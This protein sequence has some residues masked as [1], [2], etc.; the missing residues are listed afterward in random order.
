NV[1]LAGDRLGQERLARAGR[2]DEQDAF[3]D[4]RANGFIAFRVFEKIHDLLQLV[5]GFLATGDVAE[6]DTRFLLGDE[7]GA[8][9]AEAED[10]FTSAAEPAAN[11][12]PNQNHDADGNDP[13]E[14]ELREDA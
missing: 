10:G 9:F 8:A 3:G 5:F 13:G 14:H 12:S 7:A 6:F 4:A 2:A 11:E 1:R